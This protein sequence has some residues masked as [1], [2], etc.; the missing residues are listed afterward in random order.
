M[1]SIMKT[2]NEF[3]K[4]EPNSDL[5]QESIDTFMETAYKTLIMDIEETTINACLK[6][7]KDRSVTKADRRKRAEILIKIGQKFQR[8]GVDE[9]EGMKDIQE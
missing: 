9:D 8:D 4:K 2:A 7:V 6:V 3:R 5:N 1:T